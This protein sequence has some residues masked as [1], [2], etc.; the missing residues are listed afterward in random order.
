MDILHVIVGLFLIGIGFLVKSAPGL[1]AGYNTMPEE[2]KKNV[3]IN[4]LSTYMRNAM[5]TMGL[6]IIVG[7]FLFK[8]IGFPML[9]NAII[10]IVLL[11]GSPIMVVNAQKFDR[12]REKKT[13]QI[14]VVFGFAFAFVAG[15]ITYGLMPSQMHITDD[16]IRFSGMYGTTIAISGIDDVHLADNIPTIKART[17]GFSLGAT[18]KGTFNLD[19]WGNSRL[20]IHSD[21]PS[22]LIISQTDG[23]KT[24]VNFKDPAKTEAKY[25]RIKE[26]TGS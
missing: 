2:K 15:M 10:L 18:K 20:L 12:N 11:I 23:R 5:V 7:Y 8:W 19:E 1:I 26:V 17:N 14:Y 13:W 24:I 25:H 22:Y 16:A 21:R 3:D 9:A 4:G 6:C